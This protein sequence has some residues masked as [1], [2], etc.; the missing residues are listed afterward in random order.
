[1]PYNV[2]YAFISVLDNV[3]L[4]FHRPN[5]ELILF[6]VVALPFSEKPTIL[7]SLAQVNFTLGLAVK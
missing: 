7:V 1:M 2:A 5:Y 3:K 6:F 4:S